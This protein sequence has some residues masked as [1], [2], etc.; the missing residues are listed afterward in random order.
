MNTAFITNEIQVRYTERP[1]V[2]RDFIT[3]SVPNGWDDVRHLCRRVLSYQGRRFTFTGWCS[4]KNE[5]FFAAP[6]GGSQPVAKIVR[7]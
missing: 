4:D 6:H 2:D 7:A 5:C 1:E 3:T